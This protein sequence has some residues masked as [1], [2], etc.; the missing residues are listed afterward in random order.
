MCDKCYLGETIC[1][2]EDRIKEHKSACC[3]ESRQL[4]SHEE[5]LLSTSRVDAATRG[6]LKDPG[7]MEWLW[8]EGPSLSL[9]S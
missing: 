3:R 7:N 2:L 4:L 9:I 6:C 1:R 5:E 8:I